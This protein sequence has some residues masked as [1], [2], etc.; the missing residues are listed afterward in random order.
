M[1]DVIYGSP[2]LPLSLPLFMMNERNG[3]RLSRVCF[4]RSSRLRPS[5]AAVDLR[6]RDEDGATSTVTLLLILSL[7]IEVFGCAMY[8]FRKQ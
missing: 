6:A 3:P 5:V 8:G 4:A 7:Q 2:V 1:M